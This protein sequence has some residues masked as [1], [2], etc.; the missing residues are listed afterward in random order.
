M[1]VLAV[2]DKEGMGSDFGEANEI[3]ECLPTRHIQHNTTK[4]AWWSYFFFFSAH[5]TFT[6]LHQSV[7]R[8]GIKICQKGHH[9][10]TIYCSIRMDAVKRN[11]CWFFLA[12]D[13]WWSGK[14]T[15]NTTLIRVCV[16]VSVCLCAISPRRFFFFSLD[17]DDRSGGWWW[18][19]HP[20]WWW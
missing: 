15:G 11:W 12:T 19:W 9:I 20:W 3:G 1:T 10:Y 2:D 14:L 16:L 13:W 6:V 5:A 17:D 18:W 7:I 4:L 8:L